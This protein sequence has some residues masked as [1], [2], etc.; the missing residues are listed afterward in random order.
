MPAKF[1]GEIQFS[2]RLPSGQA[3]SVTGQPDIRTGA[4]MYG[5]AIQNL[6]GAF[7][8]MSDAWEKTELST[9]RREFDETSFAAFNNYSKAGDAEGRTALVKQW[10]QD[11]Q[12]I[13][14]KSGSVNRQF[15]NYLNRVQPSWA[16]NFA[17]Q[18]VKLQ[19]QQIEDS[20]NLNLAS[21]YLNG[22]IKTINEAIQRKADFR[23]MSQAEANRLKAEAPD[24]V[25][26]LRAARAAE[27]GDLS[28][29]ELAQK[30]LSNPTTEQLRRMNLSVARAERTFNSRN[31]Q[32]KEEATTATLN[33][34]AT[35]SLKE[36]DLIARHAAG[37]I[38]DSEFKFILNELRRTDTRKTDPIANASALEIITKVG[39]GVLTK[40]EAKTQMYKLMPNLDET[41]AIA[42]LGDIETVFGKAQNTRLNTDYSLGDSL[43][44][45][46]RF[47]GIPTIEDMVGF[48]A[49][50]PGEQ[51]D[52]QR[53][54][55][56][57]TQNNA[58]YK[59]A[60]NEWFQEESKKGIVSIDDIRNQAIIFRNVYRE[61][62]RLE[63]EEFERTVA[64]EQRALT[65]PP[66]VFGPPVPVRKPPSEMSAEERSRE[67]RELRRKIGK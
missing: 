5:I 13:K 42:R 67:I 17:G 66:E 28:E 60:L 15:Q 11:I 45:S 33:E 59:E 38:S 56:A 62:S 61:R 7:Q 29:A 46:R 2:E 53:K 58:L 49:L 39:Q 1:P 54:F 10:S 41:A 63:I 57:E 64:G 32:F 18:E 35:G 4:Q 55:T 36:S 65:A 34:W 16:Q 40:Q 25:L 9:M 47:R 8:Q 6:G 20:N 31:A 19:K 14:S 43:I 37:F 44:I 27:L 3:P 12:G 50:T 23:Q 30:Q 24:E 51:N 52:E 21:A 22:D 26:V 48:S